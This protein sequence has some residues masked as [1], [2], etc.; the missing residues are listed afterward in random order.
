MIPRLLEFFTPSSI[1]ADTS[2]WEYQRTQLFLVAVFIILSISSVCTGLYYASGSLLLGH[3]SILTAA[4]ACSILAL[5]RWSQKM[6][7]PAILLI[8]YLFIITVICVCITGGIHSFFLSV[9]YAPAILA[10]VMFNRIVMVCSVALSLV[11]IAIFIV[12]NELGIQFPVL[13]APRFLGIL[14][15]ILQSAVLVG[16]LAAFFYSE[17]VRQKAFQLLEGERDSVQAKIRIATQTLQEQQ[18]NILHIN[19]NLERQNTQLESAIQE[20]E[21][22]KKLQTEFLRNVSHE[23]R[24]PLTA[25]MGFTEIVASRLPSDDALSRG[26]VQQ[27]SIAGQNLMNIFSNILTLASLQANT[28]QYSFE[29][30]QIQALVNDVERSIRPIAEQKGLEFRVSVGNDHQDY[31]TLDMHHTRDIMRHLLSNAIKFTEKGLVSLTCELLPL[32]QSLRITVSDTGI[33]I[34]TNDE[35]LLF[36]PFSQRDGSKTREYEGLGLGLA[37][38]KRLVDGMRGRIWYES[39]QG[40]GSTFIVELPLETKGRGQAPPAKARA[41]A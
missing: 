26:F 4:F 1:A 11:I 12:L 28:V 25:V 3:F 37:I 22:A 38:T 5:M 6:H 40:Q 20:A 35:Q 17:V 16:V 21:G 13:F 9:L 29:L 23:V 14:T 7:L 2:S 8:A 10:V 15:G 18:D 36:T 33:G 19:S 27:I 34:D 30:V 39:A 24:T 32:H 41:I 31:A